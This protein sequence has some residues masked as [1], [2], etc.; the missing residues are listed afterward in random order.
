MSII[1]KKGYGYLLILTVAVQKQAIICS[2]D[3]A[4]LNPGILVADLTWFPI[5]RRL[6]VVLFG[7]DYEQFIGM[8]NWRYQTR[9]IVIRSS[10]LAI[11]AQNESCKGSN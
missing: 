5:F 11:S 3:E 1:H 8:L 7:V 6:R 9:Y 10:R 4:E 2:S